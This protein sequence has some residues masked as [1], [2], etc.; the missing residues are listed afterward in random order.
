VLF[1]DELDDDDSTDHKLDSDVN[2]NN[3]NNNNGND[4]DYCSN[5]H[6]R[7]HNGERKHD[8]G[9]DASNDGAVRQQSHCF[10]VQMRRRQ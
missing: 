7:V 9:V 10:S 1:S 5:R 6:E 2:N 8:D 3:N 4:N